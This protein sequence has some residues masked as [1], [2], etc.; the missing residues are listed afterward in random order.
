MPPRFQP[1]VVGQDAEPVEFRPLPAAEPVNTRP[2]FSLPS[3]R[4][5]WLKARDAADWTDA[6]RDWLRGYV[7]DPDGYGLF[8]QRFDLL[9]IAWGDAD[10][11]EIVNDPARVR[12]GGQ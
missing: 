4:Y 5:E 11:A 9:G 3:E 6:D 10:A 2:A 12:A 8:A 7:A 1:V